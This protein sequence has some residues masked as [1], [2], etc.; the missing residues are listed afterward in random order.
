MAPESHPNSARPSRCC[1]RM[2]GVGRQAAWLPN[3]RLAC[4]PVVAA[5]VM[6]IGCVGG[7]REAPVKGS[8]APRLVW[9]A[10]PAEARVR[11]VRTL[12]GRRDVEVRGGSLR[13]MAAAITGKRRDRLVR[14]V[15]IAGREG[16]LSVVDAGDAALVLIDL[17]RR[18]FRRLTRLGDQDVVS[19]VGVAVAGGFQYVSDSD[20]ARVL[21]LD[22][23]GRFLRNIGDGQLGRPTG[24]A[25]DGERDRLYVADTTAHRV[26]A[27]SLDGT[28]QQVIGRRGAGHGEFNFPTQLQLGPGG[29]LFVI[30]SLNYRVQS[31]DPQGRFLSS[32]GSQGDGSGH[33]ARP[34]GIAID[35]WGHLYIV[36]ALFDAI[37]V[38]DPSGRLLLTFGE[39]GTGRGQFSLPAGIYIDEH[40]RIYV[41]DSY[42]QRVQVF[43]FLGST[44]G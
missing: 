26:V 42:N 13:R 16:R 37:Q 14:P 36:D 43:Q 34:R 44:D 27:F 4:L 30:D 33:F 9:P 15:A 3:S 29:T 28:L 2:R 18:S 21:V 23:H 19:P 24:L 17:E 35:S 11:Y 32:F 38:F 12:S 25:V 31:F 22:E 6:A 7:L 20:L 1:W 39:R 10:P 8:A 41:A 5:V 40:D